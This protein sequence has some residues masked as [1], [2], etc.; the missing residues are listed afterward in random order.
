MADAVPPDEGQTDPIPSLPQLQE[1]YDTIEALMADLNSW[2]KQYSLGFAKRRSANY[3]EGLPMFAIVAIKQPL[4]QKPDE[5]LLRRPVASG[6]WLR[7][8]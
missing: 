2:G 8:L 5:Q 7:Q 1:T 6:Q 4:E 3:I